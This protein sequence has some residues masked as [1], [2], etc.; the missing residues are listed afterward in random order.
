MKIPFSKLVGWLTSILT[1]LAG[2]S[3][4]Q[5]Q[6]FLAQLVSPSLAHILAIVIVAVLALVSRLSHAAN[7]T[8]GQP[9]QPTDLLEMGLTKNLTTR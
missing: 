6:A 1:V 8:G 5:I 7:G 4:E 9:P 3:E 2:L